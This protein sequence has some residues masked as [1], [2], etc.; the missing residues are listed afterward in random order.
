MRKVPLL[1]SVAALIVIAW[2]F[3]A[4]APDPADDQTA[5]ASSALHRVYIDPASGQLSSGPTGT[6]V[7][8]DKNMM[9]GLN[10][11]SEGLVQKD[12]PHGGKG[13]HLN[14]RF[15]E[16]GIATIDADGKL[17][18]NYVDHV[19]QDPNDNR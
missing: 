2:S 8:L 18:I 15:R 11:S 17:T 10:R 16:V 5:E 13:V 4:D 12:G 3:H 7:D 6:P 19:T 14:G 9:E 1:F